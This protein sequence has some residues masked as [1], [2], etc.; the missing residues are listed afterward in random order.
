MD[1]I[2]EGVQDAR[3]AVLIEVMSSRGIIPT[4]AEVTSPPDVDDAVD[5][6]DDVVDDEEDVAEDDD[7]CCCFLFAN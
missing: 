5:D 7:D 4:E 1:N 6:V 3:H 2:K